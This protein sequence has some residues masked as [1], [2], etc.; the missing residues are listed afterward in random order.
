M[1][2]GGTF[3]LRR[4]FEKAT[5]RARLVRRISVSSVARLAHAAICRMSSAPTPSDRKRLA[6]FRPRS[7]V[8][9]CS[10]ARGAGLPVSLMCLA[11]RT[12]EQDLRVGKGRGRMRLC[13]LELRAQADPQDRFRCRRKMGTKAVRETGRNTV[14]QVSPTPRKMTDSA[15]PA[16]LKARHRPRRG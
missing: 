2:R 12:R 4:T 13:Q 10:C 3:S 1:I 16:P 5:S 8:R 11:R 15:G 7:R 6:L 9:P 14:R